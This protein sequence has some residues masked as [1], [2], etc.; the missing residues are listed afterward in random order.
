MGLMHHKDLVILHVRVIQCLL[1]LSVLQ[2]KGK[3]TVLK[4]AS[5]T[6]YLQ[7]HTHY[8]TVV[9]LSE[10]RWR[11]FLTAVSLCFLPIT[12][13]GQRF[14]WRVG[15]EITRRVIDTIIFCFYDVFITFTGTMKAKIRWF[16]SICLNV[17]QL[18]KGH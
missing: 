12:K 8:A 18:F 15:R 14:I 3:D 2:A 17:I 4:S 11:V 16:I 13:R 9:W 5:I 7:S 1:E 10:K 6:C